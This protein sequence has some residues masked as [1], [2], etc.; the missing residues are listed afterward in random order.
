MRM[1]NNKN[2]SNLFMSILLP[3]YTYYEQKEQNE[4]KTI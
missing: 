4:N 1:K 3:L 2:S